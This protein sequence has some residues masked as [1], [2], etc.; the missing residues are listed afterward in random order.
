MFKKMMMNNDNKRKK[1]E[2]ENKP[3]HILSNI[4]ICF[5]IYISICTMLRQSEHPNTSS[6][7]EDMAVQ[8][9]VSSL[10]TPMRWRAAATSSWEGG[11]SLAMGR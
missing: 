11:S 2:E 7:A 8:S 1:R 9:A 6:A 10:T 4:H 3:T 5:H